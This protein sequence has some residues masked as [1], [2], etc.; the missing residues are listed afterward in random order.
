MTSQKFTLKCIHCQ[1][2]IS[3]C[4]G[5]APGVNYESIRLQAKEMDVEV[6]CNQCKKIFLFHES[7]VIHEQRDPTETHSLHEPHGLHEP[8]KI[9]TNPVSLKKTVDSIQPNRDYL[10]P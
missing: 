6:Y 5:L 7:A 3:L 8:Q 4:S 2:E 9:I 10:L 1:N